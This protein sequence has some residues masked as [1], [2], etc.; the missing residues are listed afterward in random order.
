M[1]RGIL[2]SRMSGGAGSAPRRSRGGNCEKVRSSRIAILLL[3]ICQ[4]VSVDNV[5]TY[6]FGSGRIS[7]GLARIAYVFWASQ[8]LQGLECSSS[9]TSGTHDPSSEGF[10]L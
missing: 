4:K 9:P 1:F 7:V 6:G 5:H 2:E 3:R 10:L 8:R